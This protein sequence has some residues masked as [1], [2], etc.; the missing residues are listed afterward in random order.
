MGA[1]SNDAGKLAIMVG[2]CESLAHL[3]NST[4]DSRVFSL[5]STVAKSLQSAGA[6]SVWRIDAVKF[7]Y[8]FHSFHVTFYRNFLILVYAVL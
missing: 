5:S 2:F 4:I 3:I 7:P 6:A 8:V 1:I